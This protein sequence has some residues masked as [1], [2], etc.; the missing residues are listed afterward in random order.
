MEL[1]LISSVSKPKGGIKRPLSEFAFDT[2]FVLP[3]HLMKKPTKTTQTIQNTKQNEEQATTT[4]TQRN[5]ANKTTKGKHKQTQPKTQ[6]AQTNPE[7]STK[8]QRTQRGRN[9][10]KRR[11][12]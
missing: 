4:K 6:R 8:T 11:E 1:M 9:N 12:N 2:C 3:R 5:T 7:N 10:Q